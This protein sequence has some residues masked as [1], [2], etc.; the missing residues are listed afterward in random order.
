MA[1]RI[2]VVG[3]TLSGPTAAARARE[4]DGDASIT[5]VQRG[6]HLSF[7][8]AGLAHHLSGEVTD[9]SRLDRQGAAFFRDVYAIDALLHTN[10]T[11]LDVAGRT[12][13]VTSTDGGTESSRA[14]PWDELIFALGAESLPLPGVSGDNVFRLRSFGDVTDLRRFI[15]DRPP[16]AGPAHVVVVGA[17]SFGLEAVDGLVRAGARVTLL[18]QSPSLLPRFTQTVTGPLVAQLR[19]RGVE[20]RQGVAVIGADRDTDGRVVQALHLADGRADGRLPCDAVV[21]CAGVRPRTG[22]L[23]RAGIALRADGCVLVDERAR[24]LPHVY[25]CG[26]SVAVPNAVSGTPMWWAQAAIADKVAQVAGENAGGGSAQTAPF[27][28]TMVLRVLDLTVGR[29]GLSHDEA[30]MA[31]GE[32]DVDVSVVV[33]RSHEVWWPGARALT[34]VL[35]SQRSTGRVLGAEAIGTVDVDKRIDVAATAIVGR[36]TVDQLAMLDLGYAGAFN[37]T[38]DVWNTAARLATIERHHEGSSIT[39]AEFRRRTDWVVVDV[40]DDVPTDVPTGASTADASR[41]ALPGAIHIPLSVLRPALHRL[42]KTR[43][44]VVY[45]GR[46]RRG[47]VAMQLLRQQGFVDVHNLAGGLQAL[48][49]AS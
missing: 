8:F 34:A 43:P 7:A 13:T 44:T 6:A 15:T 42:D 1:R 21:V 45:S 26:A 27:A 46:G 14:L 11:D 22:L 23:A 31:F 37:A 33:G 39:A 17:G 41:A 29:T 28:G 30:V 18:E 2:V 38:R 47:F 24:V 12:L 4:T 49:S 9:L 36:L 25:A 35:V 20:V 10:A 48:R 5:I 32:A 3:G 16:A 40:R 19:E